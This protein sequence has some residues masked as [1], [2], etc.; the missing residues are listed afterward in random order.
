MAKAE[1]TLKEKDKNKSVTYISQSK[2][3]DFKAIK[4]ESNGKIYVEHRILA[5]NL[6]KRKLATFENVDFELKKGSISK[7]E[8]VE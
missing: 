8:D 5:E 4:L 6:V 7:I 3:K 2:K 1:I